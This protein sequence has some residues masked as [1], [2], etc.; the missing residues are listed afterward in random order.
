MQG[1]GNRLYPAAY[2]FFEQRRLSE[3]KPK[4]KLRLE[5]EA[6]FPHGHSLERD[7]GGCYVPAGYVPVIDRIGRLTVVR[8]LPKSG[9]LSLQKIGELMGANAL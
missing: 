4:S 6:A 1:S 7:S 9:R 2:L 5:S 8:K 3:G